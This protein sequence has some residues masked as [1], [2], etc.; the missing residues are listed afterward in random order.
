MRSILATQAGAPWEGTCL[1]PIWTD[2]GNGPAAAGS[3]RYLQFLL[4]DGTGQEQSG[5]RAPGRLN[6]PIRVD[7]FR[8]DSC[9]R[10]FRGESG[11][12][13]ILSFACPAACPGFLGLGGFS[14]AVF[15]RGE[16][17]PVWAGRAQR[18]AARMRRRAGSAIGARGAIL[19]A[20]RKVR[21]PCRA[22]RA[23]TAIRSRR[24]VRV[25]GLRKGQ[26]CQDAGG[27]DQVIRHV[28]DGKP[29]GVRDPRM[30]G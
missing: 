4:A 19:R 25:R 10:S 28:R 29:G 8:L 12:T 26:G 23:A 20:G 18:W 27:A 16:C 9:M 1:N 21:W 24:M 2:R 17:G 11:R 30:Q 3:A 15:G 6:R 5:Y 7:H 22:V 13:G 14:V